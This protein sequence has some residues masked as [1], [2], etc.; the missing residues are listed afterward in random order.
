M[1]RFG[2]MAIAF[3]IPYPDPRK[4]GQELGGIIF[5]LLITGPASF[6]LWLIN[7]KLELGVVS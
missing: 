3:R 5:S 4:L 7:F 1:L 2:R 6:S